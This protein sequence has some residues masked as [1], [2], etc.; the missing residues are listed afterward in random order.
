MYV[1]I[2]RTA[3]AVLPPCFSF[4]CSFI[5]SDVLPT[6][7]KLPG[8]IGFF[9]CWTLSHHA[10]VLASRHRRVSAD[11]FVMGTVVLRARLG[12]GGILILQTSNTT[13]RRV[14]GVTAVHGQIIKEY[15]L[16]ITVITISKYIGQ[17]EWEWEQTTSKIDEEMK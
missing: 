16:Y 13:G 14:P 5:R 4:D 7:T 6:N 17:Q 2:N 3:V 12:L 1:A 8:N 15:G 10:L 9:P 11:I